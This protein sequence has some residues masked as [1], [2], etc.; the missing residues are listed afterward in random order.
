MS[1]QLK[2]IRTLE[3]KLSLNATQRGQI[4]AW[5]NV[6]RMFWNRG[7]E[8]LKE[9]EAFTA[10]NKHDK[11]SAPC[12]P[13]PWE[14]RWVPV[15]SEGEW[16]D[17]AIVASYA[18]G[19]LSVANKWKSS[20]HKWRPM[21]LPLITEKVVQQRSPKPAQ[22][23]LLQ[24][25]FEADN[26]SSKRTLTQKVDAGEIIRTWPDIRPYVKPRI[27]VWLEE[28]PTTQ[29]GLIRK[30][31][32]TEARNRDWR[33]ALSALMSHKANSDIE[34]FGVPAKVTQTTIG[35]LRIAFDKYI[36]RTKDAAGRLAGCPQFKSRHDTK[37]LKTISDENPPS[38][39]M[40]VG[41]TIKLPGSLPTLKVKT[42]DK[43]WPANTRVKSYRIMREPSGYYLLLVGEVPV[44]APKPT[45]KGAG[46][47]AGLVHIL[48]DDAGKHYDI[49][50]P[51]GRRL[52]KLARLQ[53]KAARQQKGS[54][55]QQKTYAQ[56]A[57]VHEKARR[58]RKAWHHKLST[59]AVR[60]YDA[61]AVET[62]NLAGMGK[63]AKPKPKEDGTGYERNNQA[64]KRA[65]NRK[66]R[67]AGWGQLLS[68]MESKAKA[69]DR[70]FERVPA[71]FTSQT[72]NRC[73]EVT[74]KNRLTQSSFVCVGCGHA[75][76]ADTNAA[77]NIRDSAFPEFRESYP[78]WGQGTGVVT[79]GDVKPVES[80]V[81]V[82]VKQEAAQVA[83]MGDAHPIS[84]RAQTREQVATEGSTPCNLAGKQRRKS[85]SAQ[86]DHQTVA[87]LGLWDSAPATG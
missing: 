85:R 3:F 23:P 76:N 63:R 62:L 84:K 27:V 65:L 37:A 87:Q 55:N 79:P 83:P 74:K 28:N 45:T 12:C 41:N 59:F 16:R 58:D 50:A 32:V 69:W 60:K 4:D 25:Q 51:L 78:A 66:M 1:Q 7:L 42:L 68:M 81:G 43:R 17:P 34:T 35:K 26:P 46:F 38:G 2:A 56:A 64:A 21:P 24:A 80:P 29:A 86:G 61:I 40:P 70:R 47:D 22:C 13:V 54:A 36:T 33:D 31:K 73:G 75:D 52:K 72:C 30:G 15:N 19:W 48:N 14:Y 53:R 20:D 44:E 8:L 67:D 39:L 57:R 18:H 71:A 11:V 5:P 6:Q 10:Y 9:F 82:T 77:K 49:P